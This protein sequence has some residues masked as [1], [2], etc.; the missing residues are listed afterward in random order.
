[1]LICRVLAQHGVAFLVVWI[2][3]V[4]INVEAVCRVGNLEAVIEIDNKALEV[5]ALSKYSLVNSI[6]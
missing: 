6:R 5:V 2:D 3:R 1:M 4:R